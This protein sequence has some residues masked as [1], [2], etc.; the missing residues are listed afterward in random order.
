MASAIPQER[1]AE[2]VREAR[3]RSGVPV[4]AAALLVGRTRR[5]RR[6]RAGRGRDAVPDRV[7]HEVGSR[8]R[9]AVCSTS[10]RPWPRRSSTRPPALAH[11]RPATEA[12]GAL[13]SEACA[14]SGRIRMPAS[15]SWATPAQRLRRDVVLA[16]VQ[17]APARSAG[18]REHELR[19]TACGRAGARTGGCDGRTASL[20]RSVVS[21]SGGALQAGSGRQSETCFGSRR[22]SSAAQALA[23]AE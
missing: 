13:P 4:A 14:G 8:R 17:R 16:A 2:I 12:G 19:G 6:G 18:A 7:D 3:A 22:T 11:R 9:C 23:E 5:A 21:G 1:L 10:R 15:C 20:P